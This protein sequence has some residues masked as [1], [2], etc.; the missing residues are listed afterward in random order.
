MVG[1]LNRGWL[2]ERANRLRQ[3]VRV[4]WHLHPLGNLAFAERP[5][6]RAFRVNDRL[7][8]L[9]LLPLE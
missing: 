1:I 3:Q 2:R 7:F 6:P 4:V 9:H 5:F 8:V